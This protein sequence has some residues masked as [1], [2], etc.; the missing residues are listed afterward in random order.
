MELYLELEEGESLD[1]DRLHDAFERALREGHLIPV[2]FTSAET[3]V[4]IAELANVI[5]KVM[6][7][8]LEG[9]RPPFRSSAG[10]SVEVAPD[11]DGPTVAHVFKVS[12]DA[13]VGKLGVFRIHR[14]TVTKDSQLH[15][16]DA[17][18][19][20]KVGHLFA[21]QGKEH[22]RGR[23]RDRRRH[24][25]GGEDRR[26]DVRR[27]DARVRG[28]RGPLHGGGRPAGADAG[29]RHRDEDPRRRAE[30]RRLAL[31]ARG[32]GPVPLHRAQRGVQRDG[33]PRPRRPSPAHG[34][35]EDEGP[36]QR[37]GRH[38]AAEKSPTARRSASR[39]RATIATRSRPGAPGS[40]A[41][42]T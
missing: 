9:N 37:R 15:V 28:R 3:G 8:P 25:R 17:R 10:E 35:G 41:R 11:A 13:F 4:G 16:G 19:P 38:P 36:V 12:I 27:G 23:R 18:K 5:E 30:A 31:E 1:A 24:L 32:G 26:G 6:P 39:P 22:N 34:A 42:C 2:C 21:L 33:R 40:S 29:A 14:G 7:S 20:V